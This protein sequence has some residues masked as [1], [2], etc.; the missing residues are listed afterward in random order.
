M[1]GFGTDLGIA[2][3]WMIL[4]FSPIVIH[5]CLVN[6]SGPLLRIKHHWDL[7]ALFLS[8]VWHVCMAWVVTALCRSGSSESKNKSWNTSLYTLCISIDLAS[9]NTDTQ[10]A[11]SRATNTV[12]F[13]CSGSFPS[14]LATPSSP[15]WCSFPC[16]GSS[17]F[18]TCPLPLGTSIGEYSLF[19]NAL[20]P[21]SLK[22]N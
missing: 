11:R 4:H 3:E 14:W 6:E 18:S 20:C 15:C 12:F 7:S 19:T 17:S 10:G 21:G 8:G 2:S 22:Q 9:A 5:T 16:T 13:P 1:R